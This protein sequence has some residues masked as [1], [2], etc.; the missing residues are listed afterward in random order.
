MKKLLFL[1]IAAG[2]S[3][4]ASAQKDSTKVIDNK[5]TIKWVISSSAAVI[6]KSDSTL[7]FVTPKQVADSSFAKF[8]DN[9]L[10]KNGQTLELGGTLNRVT[11]IQTSA[12]NFLQITGLQSGSN[13]ADSVMVVN[14][15]TG[16][17]KYISASSLFN[18]LAFDNGLTK[19]GNLVELGG[20]LTKATT[21]ATDA[22]NNLKIT[23]LQ[24][25]SLATDSI[26]VS[27][28]DGTLKRVAA[29]SVLQSGAESFTA[30]T[31]QTAYAVPNLPI[32][33]S[34]VWVYRN[35]AKLAPIADY[36]TTSGQV[37][38]TSAVGSLVAAGD[39]IEV[40]WVK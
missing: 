35:G 15:S 37:S 16:Q 18:A 30:T 20:T 25:G 34:K 36:T 28:A 11:T 3:F 22:T 14:P 24:S 10:T 39:L 12:S 1:S 31:G 13:T 32:T 4:T 23:G 27:A 8:A 9:G 26:V 29:E 38:L 17:L 7:L 2:I 5:G 6:T 21:I 33:A 40:Q 19:T